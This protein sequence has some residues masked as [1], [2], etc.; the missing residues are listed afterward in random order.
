LKKLIIKGMDKRY[1]SDKIVGWYLEN[2]RDLPWRRTNDPYKIWLSE[3]ILQQTRVIQGLPYYERFVKK[4]PTVKSLAGAPE[5]D[6]LRLW[7]GLGYYTR[8]R[9]LHKC[10]KRVAESLGSRFPDSFSELKLLPGIGDYTAAAIA[11][12]AFKESVAVVDGNVFRVLS[13]L[14][15]S[16]T[17]INSPEGKKYFSELANQLI[18]EKNPD[19][20]NQAMMEFGATF[21]TP[22]NPS[23][24][25]CMFQ[26]SCFAFK[27]NLQLSLPV[28]LK[29]VKNRKR[30]FHYLVVKKGKQL[31]M[32]KREQKDI[33]LGLYDFPLV[34]DKK[35]LKLDKVLE[36]DLEW[37]KPA[38]KTDKS[39]TISETYKHILTHQTIF[40]RFVVID[41]LKTAIKPDKSLRFYSFDEISD[42][43]KPVL[44]S[45]FLD[46]HSF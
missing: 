14:F 5:Q 32:K 44:I 33:W 6:V 13:R 27:N 1:F 21:C 7:Q 12:I 46:D 40:C 4:Y 10:A 8:A 18:P 38:L 36:A 25:S 17:P 15:G 42:L 30:Y 23:C 29:L 43:P 39:V 41:Q 16:E 35:A 28:K 3:I 34:E 45:R 19:L 2:K 31:L 24:E 11:S 20:H 37:L 22:K 9:N 26:S